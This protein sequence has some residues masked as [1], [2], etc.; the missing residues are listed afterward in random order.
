MRKGFRLSGWP[1]KVRTGL[2]HHE[3]SYEN[4]SIYE[5]NKCISPVFSLQVQIK[6]GVV[7]GFLRLGSQFYLFSATLHNNFSL[8]EP[9]VV[10]FQNFQELKEYSNC[11]IMSLDK[12]IYKFVEEQKNINTLFKT[13]K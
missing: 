7:S 6:T 2:S 11:R 8:L 12:P 10:L 3:F 13:H 4:L 1:K 5:I 9:S